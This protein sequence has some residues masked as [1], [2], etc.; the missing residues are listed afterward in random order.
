M[1]IKPIQIAQEIEERFR[2]YLL[3]TFDFPEVYSDL[4]DQFRQA[5]LQHERLF[6][7]PYLHGLAPY[8]QDVSVKD[9]I[10][11]HVLPPAVARLPL[12]EPL[13]RPLYRHQ[14]RAIER[15]RAGHNIVVSS[16]TGSGKTLTFLAPILAEILQNQEP[17]VHALLL[18]PMNALVNDQLKNLRRI[19]R[20][21]PEVRFGRYINVHV[22]PHSERDARRL[23]PEAP[24]NEVVSRE[25]FRTTPPHI[26][27]TNYAMLEYLFLRVDDSPL[28]H[29]PWRFIVV[30]E[31]HTYA[32]AKGSEVALLLRRLRSRVKEPHDD[33]AQCIA[34]SATLG[35][36]DPKRRREVLEFARRLFDAPFGDE[37][38]ILADKAHVPTEGR[39]EP[40]KAVYVAPALLESCNAGAKWTP[41]LS[42]VLRRSGFPDH[43]VEEGAHAGAQSVEEGLYQVFRQDARVLRLREAAAEPRDLATAAEIVIGD[44]DNAAV[45]QLCGLVGVCSFARVPGGD[46]RL[47]PCRYHLFAR[48]LNGA[49]VAL[50]SDAAEIT[51]ALFLEPTKATPDGSA[52]TLELRSCRKCGQPY[53]FG[54]RVTEN[55]RNVLR[56]FGTERE[57]RPDR[58]RPLWMTWEAPRARSEDEEEET[59]DSSAP[60]PILG[61]KPA[62]GEFRD[63]RDG[64]VGPDEIA[65]WRIHEK[66]ELNRCFACG[67]QQ[68]ITPVRAD[69]AAAQAVVADAFYRCLP[70]ATSPPAR[71]EALD[72]PGHGRK[73]LAFA[74]SRQSAAYF[75]P[76]FQNSNR[77]QLMRRLIYD[78]LRRAEAKL[79]T[80]DADSLVNFM[81][82]EAEDTRLFPIH[83]SGGQRR[84]ECLRAIVRE[85]CLPF[86]RRQSLEALALV[87]S[88]IMLK[89]R[90]SPP[91]ELL[92]VLNPVEATGV[93]QALLST[94]RLL[95]ALALPDPLT[96]NDPIFQVRKGQDGF[97]A[98]GS[99]EEK[100]GYR[101]HGF[102]PERALRLQRRGQFLQ[103]VL[104]AAVKREG[105]QVPSEP[106]LRTILDRIWTSLLGGARPIFQRVAMA[107]GIVGHQLRW[108]DLSFTTRS[109]W[110]FCQKCQQWSSQDVL[111][112]CPSFRCDGIL[113]EADPNKRLAGNHYRRI[114]SASGEGPVPVTACEHTA[115]L[116]PKLAA[117][118]QLAFQDGHAP[119]SDVG[120][121]NLLSCSTTFELGVD[122]GDLEAV[123]LRNVPP[124]PANYQQ[125]AGRAGR[126][127]GTAAFAVTF[128]MPRSH[129]EHYFAQPTQMI[130]GLVRPPRIDLHNETVYSRHVNAVLLAD[131]VRSWHA[132]RSEDIT[133]I[134]QM[135]TAKAA[136]ESAPFASFLS[137]LPAAIKANYGA[138][139]KLMP[140]GDSLAICDA[141]AEQVRNAFQ[142]AADYFADEV[143]MY[144]TAIADVEQRRKQAEQDG[145]HDVAKR[146]YGFG[147]FLYSRRNDLHT[148][149][150]VE[151]FS[152]R[153]VL[154]SYAFPIYNV[155]LATADR[156]LKLER[157]LR[158]ALSEYVPGAAIVAKGKLWRS[159]G[160]RRPWQKSLERKYYSC[161]PRC[162]HVMRH[163]D[164]NEV[165]PDGICPVC[166]HDGQQ[167]VR[168][169]QPYLV[170][171]HGFTTDL[172]VNGEDLSF[173]RPERIPTSRVLFVPQQQANDPLRASLGNGATRLEV[174]TT[175]KADFFVFNDGGD[176]S[177]VGFHLCKLCDRQVTLDKKGKPEAHKT[178]L[179]KDCAGSSYDRVHLG[180]DF[181]SCA[182]RLTF[183]G[184]NE[185]YTAR[186]FWLSLLY[187]LLGGM[188][189]ALGIEDGD[190]N[191]VIRPIDP[192][193]TVGQEVVIFDDVPGGAGH[194]L[195]L[196]SEADLLGDVL[197]AAHARVANCT[198]GES[199]GCYTCLR[200]YRNQFCHDLLARGPVADYLSRLLES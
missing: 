9:L 141:L 131:F 33:P 95:K 60:F 161:C 16:G 142:Q 183:S 79:E 159:V 104:E 108:E 34:T 173:D 184:T 94:V 5:L 72:Y 121:I 49:Y 130:D 182:A 78:G 65:L 30:D 47:I 154:P 134:G 89:N 98:Q 199:A 59:D 64:K 157:D 150:W 120:Q 83:W 115:Q 126:G 88:E 193:G 2:R 118:Y 84:V 124:S 93:T 128:A 96:V 1:S 87:A 145:K 25:V 110:Y 111:R 27:V 99:T 196:E 172:M 156:D 80:V 158:I 170:P 39:F 160:I 26:L 14:A 195:R 76:Y 81:L 153:S 122:L 169:K 46:A 37:D 181:I 187:A 190:I 12:L 125:R 146:L 21:V 75:A 107:A 143:T 168:R 17:G 166:K 174:R 185:L 178:P 51:T 113:E 164:S 152:D 189:D 119:A 4:R 15:V 171:S 68:T 147:G 11:R 112:V 177:G 53:L 73:L 69:A 175:E 144:D 135:F 6:R 186:G 67:G 40:D 127:I 45:A 22:T 179:G 77:E 23:H 92:A 61:Y 129:D 56:A 24:Q 105:I 48:G 140:N 3:T 82:R 18:Y 114:L 38:L 197:R 194:A 28:F 29:G 70:A 55:D 123:F 188:S 90:W 100:R 13:T 132:S 58:G 74:D 192:G 66:A 50:A 138:L 7:G 86:G 139:D 85:F 63:L 44:R 149:D 151:F 133:Q 162:W 136:G 20:G 165:F 198:C 43:V 35:V 36:S 102:A 137:G 180:H 200:S 116:D 42:D 32:G 10:D 41:A 62:T 109:K 54:Y 31:A 19:L 117:E 148:S 191:G 176:P 163:L 52:F 57:D 103:R 71:V 167:P 101:L 8:V 97:K 106:E 155:T 91:A